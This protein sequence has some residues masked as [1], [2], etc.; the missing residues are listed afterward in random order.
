MA[1]IKFRRKLNVIFRRLLTPLI[2]E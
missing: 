2:M 1:L